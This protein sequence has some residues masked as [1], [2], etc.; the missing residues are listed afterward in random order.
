MSE[1]KEPAVEAEP[2]KPDAEP[3]DASADVEKW[4]ALARKN[5]QRAKE[6]AD[7]AKRFDELEEASRTELEKAV[8]R[9]EAAENLIAE[10]AAEKERDVIIADVA[11]IAG[12]PASALRGS[13]RDELEAHAE[14]LKALIP[15]TPGAPS[16]DGQGKVGEPIGSDKQLSPNDLLRA[17]FKKD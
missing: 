6:N 7:K 17:A 15:P 3:V 11:K 16:T 13:T 14:E 4:K 10:Q 12:V 9:A 1:P 5:E 2:V 8:A